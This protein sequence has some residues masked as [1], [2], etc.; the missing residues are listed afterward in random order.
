MQEEAQQCCDLYLYHRRCAKQYIWSKPV[1]QAEVET[2]DKG[3]DE[4][5]NNTISDSL[6]ISNASGSN[7]FRHIFKQS[8]E[9]R[10]QNQE[11]FSRPLESFDKLR[12]IL[13]FCHQ[14]LITNDTTA[15]RFAEVFEKFI[16]D[17]ETS[18][19]VRGI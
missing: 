13:G 17:R 8:Q 15:L 6:L 18:R 7:V 2:R 12:K 9:I 11:W 5:K 16:P 1:D 3:K 14:E 10:E 4:E 19:G